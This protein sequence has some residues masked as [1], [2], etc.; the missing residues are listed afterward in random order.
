GRAKAKGVI[1]EAHVEAYEVLSR[2]VGRW[3]QQIKKT[4]PAHHVVTMEEAMSL[5]GPDRMALMS[6]ARNRKSLL[7]FYD[8]VN[9][10]VFVQDF[11]NSRGRTGPKDFAAHWIATELGLS[12]SR[13][14]NRVSEL[15][16]K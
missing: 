13:F 5:I 7:S 1:S 15:R 9:W 14:Q 3:Q 4:Y 6:D 11:I 10:K 12:A 8:K 2:E 16:K